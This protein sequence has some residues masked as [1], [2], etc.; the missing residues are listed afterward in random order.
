[1]YVCM[2]IWNSKLGLHSFHVRASFQAYIL[3]DNGNESS[4][5]E[6]ETSGRILSTRKKIVI[7]GTPSRHIEG[8]L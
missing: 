1:M 5:K 2:C 8:K 3:Y 4:L 6:E 7:V